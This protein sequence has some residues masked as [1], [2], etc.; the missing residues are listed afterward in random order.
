MRKALLEIAHQLQMAHHAHQRIFGWLVTVGGWIQ[1]GPRDVRRVIGAADGDVEQ[2]DVEI[3]HRLQKFGGFI[4]MNLMRVLF[5]RAEP[6][7]V[8]QRLAGIDRNTRTQ[9]LIG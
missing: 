4:Y 1:R 5:I 6:V 9:R 8:G 2:A 3:G 7:A